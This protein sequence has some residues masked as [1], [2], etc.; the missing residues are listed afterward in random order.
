MRSSD[1]APLLARV[2]R[3]ELGF[4]QGTIVTWDPQTG[5]N[6]ISMAGS[7]LT[8]VPCLGSTE[9]FTMQPGRIVGLLRVRSQ[10]FVL[11]TIGIPGTTEFFAGGQPDLALSMQGAFP[12][13]AQQET[14]NVYFSH[15][16]TPVFVHNDR[17]STWTAPWVIGSGSQGGYR[18]RHYEEISG[19]AIGGVTMHER[20][21]LGESTVAI[22]KR[23]YTWPNELRGQLR[24]LSLEYRKTAGASGY[25]AFL[26]AGVV[27]HD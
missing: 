14:G 21:G 4:H 20:T 5:A 2:G 26:P 6:T 16:V 23:T 15:F 18:W 22:D 19:S 24:W 12:E 25:V 13:A 8:D 11:G 3:A 9:L 27:V 1:L 17:L 10:Y 7:I